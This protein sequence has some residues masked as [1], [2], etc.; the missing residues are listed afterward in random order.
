MSLSIAGRRAPLRTKTL[1]DS[2]GYQLESITSF[3]RKLRCIYKFLPSCPF[4]ALEYSC[5]DS[6]CRRTKEAG[7][8]IVKSNGAQIVDRANDQLGSAGA[9][10][11]SGAQFQ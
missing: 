6:L 7:C 1:P 2:G 9:A 8:S 4:N 10:G 3:H 11:V 5:S